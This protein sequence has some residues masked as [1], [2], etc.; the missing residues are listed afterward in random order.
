MWLMG[1]WVKSRKIDERREARLELGVLDRSV[2]QVP[3]YELR[4]VCD[5][6][7][8]ELRGVC[9]FTATSATG[10]FRFYAYIGAIDVH[11]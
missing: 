5:A 3:N 11:P 4:R 6:A 7:E 8:E 1:R 9:F 2:P 10:S